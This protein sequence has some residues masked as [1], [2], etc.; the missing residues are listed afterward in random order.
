MQL[1]YGRDKTDYK[2]LSKSKEMSDSI[3][4]VLI[5]NYLGYDF[6]K[7]KSEY[8]D[9][10]K[11]PFSISYCTTNLDGY[12][13]NE[14]ILVSK[15]GINEN[16]TTPSKYAHARLFEI[17]SESFKENFFDIFK[18]SFVDSQDSEKYKSDDIDS[19]I[20]QIA[21]LK[22]TQPLS[23]E[24]LKSILYLLFDNFR[25]ISNKV[26]IISDNVGDSYNERSID[27]IKQI[28]KYIP[29]FMRKI[30][31]FVSYGTINQKYSNRIKLVVM[32]R[33]SSEIESEL[34][35]DLLNLD[36]Q[37]IK[38]ITTD[39]SKLVVDYILSIDNLKRE[40]L[41]KAIDLEN[42]KSILTIKNLYNI[43]T[44]KKLWIDSSDFNKM[45]S[46]IYNVINP[47]ELEEDLFYKMMDI[48]EKD[49]D[50]EKFNS[51]LKYILAKEYN[52]CEEYLDKDKD[53][54]NVLLFED[55]LSVDYKQDYNIKIDVDVEYIVKWWNEKIFSM[56]KEKY[57]SIDFCKVLK[58]E[59]EKYETLD[60]QGNSYLK[61]KNAMIKNIDKLLLQEEKLTKKFVDEERYKLNLELENIKSI[62][63][64]NELAKEIDNLKVK[65]DKNKEMLRIEY[66]KKFK[67]I[68]DNEYNSF[69]QLDKFIE[70][71]KDYI[72]Q[73]SIDYVQY[74]KN[75]ELDE[76]ENKVNNCTGLSELE[77][78]LSESDINYEKEIIILNKFEK[79]IKSM[80][81]DSVNDNNNIYCGLKIC[82]NIKFIKNVVKNPLVYILVN[83][84]LNLNLYDIQTTFKEI[85]KKIDFIEENKRYL[86]FD[87]NDYNLNIKI[88][89]EKK[90]YIIKFRYLNDLL[91]YIKSKQK[92]SKLSISKL[93][94]KSFNPDKKAFIKDNRELLNLID[95]NLI[96]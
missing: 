41:F 37:K 52:I 85:N 57:E 75:H 18:Y 53:L 34:K 42:K 69:K 36:L 8:S 58:I 71:Y 32:T 38:K 89:D 76:F 31:G 22:N 23:E 15:N 74:L 10:S 35:V 86:V 81:V 51:Y 79:I 88:N 44:T 6:V 54:Y 46:W 66:G 40:E 3:A 9:V 14:M 29:Y 94:N 33:E 1:L 28:Y 39:Q 11:E 49:L 20:G 68:A 25:D 55:I 4:T 63:D 78:L 73:D 43:C 72:S 48:I 65:Y 67:E 92:K 47:N 50:S 64:L 12:L 87:V 59:K 27:I 16:Y 21:E 2:V 95:K 60:L 84:D 91:E 61:L 24:A 5:D 17:E 77:R 82:E 93:I 7:N 45:S 19:Y 70:I 13:N 80:N 62:K 26:Y 30:I 83:R 56:L 90:V 96:K